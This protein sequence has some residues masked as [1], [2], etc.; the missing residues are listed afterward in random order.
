MTYKGPSGSDGC[1][2]L[3]G[4]EV[5]AIPNKHTLRGSSGIS[6]SNYVLLGRDWKGWTDGPAALQAEGMPGLGHVG[7]GWGIQGQAGLTCAPAVGSAPPGIRFIRQAP[8]HSPAL[9][10]QRKSFHLSVK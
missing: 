1:K 4:K 10:P 7:E 9:Q 6:S 3:P 5:F 2:P 8:C